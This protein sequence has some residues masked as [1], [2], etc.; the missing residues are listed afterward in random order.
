MFEISAI[1]ENVIIESLKLTILSLD[2]ELNFQPADLFVYSIDGSFYDEDVGDAV[3]QS[4]WVQRGTTQVYAS[5]TLDP[6]IIPANSFDPIFVKKGSTVGIYITIADSLR[7]HKILAY[8]GVAIKNNDFA[9]ANIQVREGLAKQW[10]PCLNW[11][12]SLTNL[13]GTPTPH[14]LYG[15][16]LYTTA[17]TSEPTFLP[18]L[19]PSIPPSVSLVP[20]KSSMP[21]A[22][23]TLSAFP[24]LTPSL[25]PSL[26]ITPTGHPTSSAAP[27]YARETLQTRTTDEGGNDGY[28]VM[29]DIVANRPV[30]IHNIY[31]SGMQSYPMNIKIFTRS[32]SHYDAYDDISKWEV[33]QSYT[34]FTADINGGRLSFPP[35]FIGVEQ[36]RAFYIAIVETYGE[37]WPLLGG[38]L[39]GIN[40]RD[41]IWA[42]DTAINLMEGLK[43]FGISEE[44]PMGIGTTDSG[45]YLLE[46]TW[47]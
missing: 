17:G 43:F 18:S 37:I 20:S 16:L 47:F 12:D 26:S 41:G 19:M 9:D 27:S 44:K 29:F 3:D 7:N 14:A 23:P 15:S 11:G 28:G 42:N 2:P 8:S 13:D 6:V 25:Q 34:N 31:L 33:I 39:P 21:S 36:T 30:E 45:V 40:Y 32:G 1:A 4:G 5:P 38:L 10:D 35:Q 46:G 22:S 24:T